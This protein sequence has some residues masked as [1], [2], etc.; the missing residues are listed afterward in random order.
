MR[1]APPGGSDVVLAFGPF[2]LLPERKALFANNCPIRLGARAIEIL[3]TL[4]SRHGE[5]ISKEELI[6]AVWPNTHVEEANLRVHVAA[7]RKALG[8]DQDGARYIV[9]LSGRGY[10]FTAPVS[11]Q[12]S[13]DDTPLSPRANSTL[14]AHFVRVIGRDGAID[15]LSDHLGRYRF[16]T[17]VGPGGIGKTTVAVATARKLADRYRH[18]V[19]FIDLAPLNDDQLVP[20]AFASALGLSI[21]SG[22]PIPALVAHLRA[23]S[24]L[25][26]LDNCEHVIGASASL[27]EVVLR[28]A[29]DIHILATSREA[30]RVGGEW[31]YRLAPMDVP[32]DVAGIRADEARVSPAVQLFAER[33]RAISESFELSDENA[34][35]VVD[36]CR[37]LDGLP[38]AIELAAARVNV[39]GVRRLA[40][41]L[42]DRLLLLSEGRRTALPRHQTLHAT[43]EWSFS[44]LSTDEQKVLCAVSI[45]RA[46]FTF[47]S[48]AAVAMG[49]GLS[50]NAVMDCV[51]SLSDKSLV[52]IDA[53]GQ[54]VT[55]RL[56][57]S[58]RAYALFKLQEA[59]QFRDVSR[60]HAERVVDVLTQAEMDWDEM[61]ASTWV[62]LY[63]PMIDDI[64]AALLWSLSPEGD[65]EFTATLT[66][67]A[68]PLWMH[69][70]L[71]NECS[72]SVGRAL[73]RMDALTL[74]TS[75]QAYRR[76]KLLAALGLSLIYTQGPGPQIEEALHK[77]FA[78]ATSLNNVDYQLRALWGLFVSTFNQ[79]N[80]WTALGRAEIFRKIAEDSRNPS[81]ARAGD[82]LLGFALHMLGRQGE[83][84]EHVEGMLRTYVAPTRRSDYVR[85]QYDQRVAARVP[86]SAILW[87]QGFSDQAMANA[88]LAINEAQSINHALSLGYA[89]STAACPTAFL[90]GDLTAAERF[91][92]MLADHSAAHGLGPW[93]AWGRYFTGI[94]AAR[95]GQ[96]D[97]GL[98][99]VAAA[100]EE[101]RATGFVL[102]YTYYLAE[103]AEL[104]GVANRPGDGLKEIDEALSRCRR[105]EEG[106]CLPEILRIK[107][108]LLVL[109][110]AENGKA[111]G[112]E[113]FQKSIGQARFW[114]MPAWQLRTAI[115]MASLYRREGCRDNAFNLLTS[116]YAQFP[117][118]DSSVDLT[119]ARALIKQ[120]SE[121]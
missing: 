8:E 21:T 84:R 89:L 73:E 36:L 18:G 72:E 83:A 78:L 56:L 86:L 15:A 35:F 66:A 24:M 62:A 98:L 22:N 7:L 115:S 12:I 34:P 47:E 14:P 101:L 90:V 6:A 95:R 70:S 114:G 65:P 45:Y 54:V 117:E 107:G 37:R 5:T 79:G 2:K 104:L 108:D 40:E 93:S 106:W 19:Q 99:G 42:D 55:C 60:R 96:L 28:G 85:F 102:R 119:R 30:M 11:R 74:T 17:V 121:N 52:Q 20:S 67:A 105:Y 32:D 43:L 77:A 80:F 50:G 91:V 64:R 94:L 82:R 51:A 13:G 116:I 39:F 97:D 25:I 59:G 103:Y 46:A 68:V 9:N 118:G 10:C 3:I 1:V 81:D 87:L 61:D 110:G 33:A 16:V 92:S 31:I 4:V 58:T 44:L 100:L 27:V 57:D 71:L 29:P 112:E 75:A 63:G 120:L 53:T 23:K 113:L 69:L 111:M 109:S 48:A 49:A 88:S 76:M 38:L 26:L 41:M